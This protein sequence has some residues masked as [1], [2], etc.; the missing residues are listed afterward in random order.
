MQIEVGNRLNEFLNDPSIYHYPLNKEG[1]R[2]A[3]HTGKISTA[4]GPFGILES[5]GRQ[6]GYGI[7]PLQSKDLMEQIRFAGDLM[8]AR[9]RISGGNFSKALVGYGEGDKYATK[10]IK[11]MGM[12]LEVPSVTTPLQQPNAQQ[13][14]VNNPPPT[15]NPTPPSYAF[16]PAKANQWNEFKSNYLKAQQTA[17]AKASLDTGLENSMSGLYGQVANTKAGMDYYV[18]QVYN[19]A[20]NNSMF[21]WGQPNQTNTRRVN[22]GWL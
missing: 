4:F 18:G 19:G 16:D 10:V 14:N 15:Y 8:G 2:I 17:N 6:P 7:K 13:A 22:W 9:M 11:A 21:N 12:P 1:K 5:T 3:G 20:N